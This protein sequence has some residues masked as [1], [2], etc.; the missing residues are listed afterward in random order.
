MDQDLM[1]HSTVDMGPVF[2]PSPMVPPMGD[3]VA[4]TVAAA[5]MGATLLFS[6]SDAFGLS[7]LPQG[8]GVVL[9]LTVLA[10]CAR[11]PLRSIGVP[12]PIMLYELWILL[13]VIITCRNPAG[14][15]AV[16]ACTTLLKVG[17]VTCLLSV[18]IRTPRQ[19]LQL[20][21]AIVCSFLAAVV[22]NRN[23]IGAISDA[24][25]AGI[26][27][28]EGRLAGTMGNAN[29]FGLFAVTVCWLAILLVLTARARLVRG[30][31]VCAV[32]LSAMVVLWTQ[33]RKAMLGLPLSVG[34]SLML[35]A[36]TRS[37]H[38]SA[39]LWMQ[40]NWFG[41][42]AGVAALVLTI[43]L[44]AYSPYAVRVRD[45]LGGRMDASS[46]AREVMLKAGM[47]LWGMS[48]MCGAGLERFRSCYG[49][50][51]SH[52]TLI[53]VLVSTGAIGAVLYFS[54]LAVAA[55]RAY[56]VVR[57]TLHGD[58]YYT[59]VVAAVFVMLFSFFNL[60]AVMYNDRLLCPLLGAFSGF[61]HAQ[62]PNRRYVFAAYQTGIDYSEPR[63]G[64]HGPC[65]R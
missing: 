62:Y 54:A 29:T 20:S 2:T 64:N 5:Y 23:D 63:R 16:V 51:Y 41:V 35:L 40:Q 56:C 6:N 17:A 43:V 14:S 55:H 13:A 50:S 39:K 46:T 47:R 61:V 1:E 8:L 24:A 33:S 7:R 15:E 53:E 4:T 12:L 36:T 48:P 44:L 28:E 52:S 30:V 42:V 34:V 3:G 45:L 25:A 32:L 22:L 58:V 9:L 27:T 18:I 38:Q 57:N 59:A 21:F 37:R 49:E 60:F 11:R 10:E 19:M 65:G 31:A 26:V